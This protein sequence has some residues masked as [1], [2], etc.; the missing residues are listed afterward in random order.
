MHV[1]TKTLVNWTWQTYWWQPGD[2]APNNFPGSKQGMTDNVAGPWRN[3]AMCT[4]W[5]QTKGNASKDM[6]VCFNPFLE[7]S[8]SIPAG[9][10][11]NCVSCHGVATAG[12]LSANGL[13]TMNY[14]A[15]YSAPIDFTAN[16][17]TQST[18]PPPTITSTCFAD[19]TKTDFSWA[20]PSNAMVPPAAPAAAADVKK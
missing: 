4:A 8:S 3:Y 7:T 17:C 15:N 13:A 10:S 5:N 14:P 2:N 11:S 20:I 1:N 18:P 19:F 16:A 12:A 9:Q 6:V